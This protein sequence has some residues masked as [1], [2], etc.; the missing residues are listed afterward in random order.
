L[1]KYCPFC[2][3]KTESNKLTRHIGIRHKDH[4]KRPTDRSLTEI[5]KIL[6]AESR[7]SITLVPMKVIKKKIG[8]YWD[9]INYRRISFE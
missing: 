9:D 4:L 3:Y 2:P 5:G 6:G 8:P 1:I 7:R